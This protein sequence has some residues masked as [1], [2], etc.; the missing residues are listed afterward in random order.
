ML[1]WDIGKLLDEAIRK[2]YHDS[3]FKNQIL[4]HSAKHRCLEN[5]QKEILSWGPIFDRNNLFRNE[6]KQKSIQEIIDFVAAF[7]GECV[8]AEK[9]AI[10]S[11]K[12][13]TKLELEDERYEKE[14]AK[15]EEIIASE[16]K[17]SQKIKGYVSKSGIII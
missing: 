3:E 1:G 9:K 14:I 11:G 2:K 4:E 16:I 7:F 10:V 13:F 12:G 8:I 6:Q 5:L 17:E 15:H